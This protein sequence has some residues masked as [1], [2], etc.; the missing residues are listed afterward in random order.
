M[1][2]AMLPAALLMFC[3]TVTAGDDELL[4]EGARVFDTIAGVGC[5]TCHGD[6]AEG[7]LGVGPFIRGA[8]EATI[9]ATI[10]ANNEMIII[11]NTIT[12]DEIKAVAA[13]VAHLGSLQVARTLAKRGRFLPDEFSTRPGTGVQLIIKN[14]SISPHTFG[15]D[16]MG[17]DEL[18][19]AGRS[20]ASIEWQAPDTP[21]VFALY[22]T[23]CK[24]KDQFFTVK[25]DPEAP[26]FKGTPPAGNVASDDGR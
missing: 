4:E 17:I 24:I 19:I 7:D 2:T 10:D 18:T 8:T 11:K 3:G 22:C 5:K 26:E 20:T 6:Y 16:D 23:D 1:R 9:R 14:S 25:V 21:G 13:Y 15:S 12:E